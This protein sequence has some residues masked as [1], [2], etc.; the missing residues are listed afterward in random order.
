M[1]NEFLKE[2]REFGIRF[3]L[4]NGISQDRFKEDEYS[5]LKILFEDDKKIKKIFEIIDDLVKDKNFE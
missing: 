3:L 5:I 4:S 1:Y 2:E